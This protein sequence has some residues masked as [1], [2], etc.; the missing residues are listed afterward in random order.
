VIAA[1]PDGRA[2]VLCVG[3]V[4]FDLLLPLP[5]FPSRDSKVMIDSSL[6]TAGGPAYNAA[7][8]VASWGLPSALAA[9][10]GA[11]PYGDRAIADFEALG[12]DA[13]LVRRD[14]GASTP[15][16]VILSVAA[17]GSRTIVTRKGPLAPL[18]GASV[19]RGLPFEPACLLA[20]G[21]ES[22][23]AAAV[24]AAYPDIPFVL[25]AGSPR[26]GVDALVPLCSH[27]VVSERY[28]ASLLG[29]TTLTGQGEVEAALAALGAKAVRAAA[30]GNG[31]VAVTLGARGW[32]CSVRGGAVE[33][34]AAYR[35]PVVDS[36]GAGDIF[37]GAFAW[38]LASGMDDRPALNLA[39]A[40]AALS[41]GT[42]GGFPSIPAREA[43]ERLRREQ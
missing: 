27:C 18:D 14:A 37:H 43:A 19:L 40:A 17:D 12:G 10:V 31:V 15:L 30:G 41:V 5:V 42:R 9:V 34:A 35:V 29:K 24:A 8:L 39:G 7:A 13:S 21:H 33:H 26:P 6:E 28:A 2:G 22:G 16:S 38:A 36:T 20:D 4:S 3:H 11:D 23:A 32:A 25:D 1:A